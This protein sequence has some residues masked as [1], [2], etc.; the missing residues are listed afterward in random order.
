LHG[1]GD[2]LGVEGDIQGEGFGVGNFH[3]ERS[4]QVVD[5]VD[6][7]DGVDSVAK[8]TDICIGQQPF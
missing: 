2:A 6:G 7:V 1:T 5:G 8:C 4:P 3:N